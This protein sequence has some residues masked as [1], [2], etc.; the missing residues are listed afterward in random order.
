MGLSQAWDYQTTRRHSKSVHGLC[1]WDIGVTNTGPP[2]VSKEGC[3][4]ATVV[5]D[6]VKCMRKPLQL[7]YH[8]GKDMKYL[9]LGE[10]NKEKSLRKLAGVKSLL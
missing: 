2:F 8:L 3:L 6:A 1:T 5:N 9:L 4:A 7:C 10:A